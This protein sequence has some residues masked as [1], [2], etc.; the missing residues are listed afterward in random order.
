MGE[1]S[2]GGRSRRGRSRRPRSNGSRD[3]RRGRSA[4]FP[5]DDLLEEEIAAVTGDDP[6]AERMN[7]MDLNGQGLIDSKRTLRRAFG[8]DLPPSVVSR[9]KMSFPTPFVE[10][11]RGALQETVEAVFEESPL[12]GTLFDREAVRALV[13]SGN[14][15]VW[16]VANLC[17]WSLVGDGVEL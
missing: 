9:P 11:F 4:E 5:D 12:V 17:L 3:P 14:V 6:E 1:N 8:A 2:N 10:A 13:G 7:V 15:A 16:P